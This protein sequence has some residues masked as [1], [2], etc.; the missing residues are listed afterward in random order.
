MKQSSGSLANK[1]M[2]TQQRG[3]L[4]NFQTTVMD[5]MRQK[6]DSKARGR[7]G[8]VRLPAQEARQ[9][10]VACLPRLPPFCMCRILERAA[11]ETPNML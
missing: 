6:N 5:G 11:P 10:P 1:E 2:K 7:L 4:R 9:S 3:D 8:A